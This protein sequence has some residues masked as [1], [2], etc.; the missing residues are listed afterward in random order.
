MAAAH[1]T[2]PGRVPLERAPANGVYRGR[3]HVRTLPPGVSGEDLRAAPPARSRTPAPA[4]P[5]KDRLCAHAGCKNRRVP[6]ATVCAAHAARRKG[7]SRCGLC[8]GLGHTQRTC[9]RAR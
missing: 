6:G 2:E 8:G 4:Q 7:A 1:S 3:L 9:R 5:A